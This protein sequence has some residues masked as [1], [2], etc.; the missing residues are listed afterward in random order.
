MLQKFIS[1]QTK[2]TEQSTTGSKNK[3]EGA[4]HVDRRKGMPVKTIVS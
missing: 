2:R 1:D 3:D 4:A